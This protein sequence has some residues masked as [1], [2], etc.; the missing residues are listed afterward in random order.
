MEVEMTTLGIAPWSAS[1][2]LVWNLMELVK[3]MI[4]KSCLLLP[5]NTIK[6]ADRM[7]RECHCIFHLGHNWCDRNA[8]E[9][10]AKAEL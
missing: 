10:L 6:L 5:K 4:M 8:A 1:P 3:M 7:Q 2:M 9:D